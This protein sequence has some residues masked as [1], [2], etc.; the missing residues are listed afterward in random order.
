MDDA[1]RG[2]HAVIMHT[3]GP[4]DPA[5]GHNSPAVIM[6]DLNGAEPRR[7][8]MDAIHAGEA[9]ERDPVHWRPEQMHEDDYNAAVV[10]FEAKHPARIDGSR[11][12][13]PNPWSMEG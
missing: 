2:F 5:T 11:A 9:F 4:D 10:A 6:L 12:Q 3:A 13:I 7:V 8:T 1:Q